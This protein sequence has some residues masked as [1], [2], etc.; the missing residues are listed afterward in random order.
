MHVFARVARQLQQAATAARRRLHF[1]CSWHRSLQSPCSMTIAQQ[2][3]TACCTQAMAQRLHD[4]TIFGA[5]GFTGQH[6]VEE[7][8]RVVPPSLRCCGSS[9]SSAAA[10]VRAFRSSGCPPRLSL[11]K[12]DAGL[13]CTPPPLPRSICI[14]GR[15][16]SKLA[17]LAARLGASGS[18]LA[19]LGG[20]EVADPGSLQAMAQQTRCAAARRRGQQQQHRR[21]SAG[22][23]ASATTAS[24]PVS[25]HAGCCLT[26]PAH[27]G[28]WASPCL[29]RQL[30]LA[31]T[32]WT[33]AAS[34]VRRWGA[35]ASALS[36]V[37]W[38]HKH[39]DDCACCVACTRASVRQLSIQPTNHLRPRLLCCC[40]AVM[41]RVH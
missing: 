38:R 1:F 18:R 33:Y 39:M 13:P 28:R 7:A 40:L 37:A 35:A 25:C 32:I 15:S 27:S 9:S 24:L 29:R 2:H 19:V 26:V 5:T 23:T 22:Q 34:Q 6:V 14:A 4:L 3:G 31:Q 8:L 30:Q 10:T 11:H 12:L 36:G 20:V 41:A 17:A 21:S 16:S